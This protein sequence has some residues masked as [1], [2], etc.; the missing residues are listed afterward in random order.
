MMSN[1]NHPKINI[2]LIGPYPP[3]AGGIASYIKNFLEQKIILNFCNVSLYQVGRK[4]SSM[5]ALFQV[6]IDFG[7]ILKYFFERAYKSKD[8]IYIHTPSYYGFF[9][10]IPY[11]VLSKIFS[12][13]KIIL[14]IHGGEFDVFFKESS[15]FLKQIIKFT[16]NSADHIIVT[17]ESW[18]PVVQEIGMP[19]N[20]IHSIPNAYNIKYFYP[21]DTLQARN[22]LTF[23]HHKKII[24]TVGALEECKG[25]IFLIECVKIIINQREDILLIIVG[26]GSLEEDLKRIISQQSLDNFIKI[27]KGNKTPEEL[28]LYINASDLF[29]LPSL[30]EGNPTVMFEA[31]GCGK[32]FVGTRVGGV[33]GVIS[34]DEYGLLVDPA[35]PKDLA[36][37]ILQALN[38]EWDKEAILQHAERYTWEN[39]AREIIG[40][41]NQVLKT[42]AG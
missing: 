19:G 16:L 38:R 28:N 14:H 30:Y 2:L 39:I 36:E 22:I 34:S 26:S 23:P 13:G 8:I 12:D 31:L 3:P 7:Q 24:L 6:L 18:I 32:P 40:V 35:N 41:Y 20:N 25:H 42:S 17:S 10:N 33:P 15:K 11:I 9:R 5:P 21:F 29:V 27:I 37:K 1:E 4:N